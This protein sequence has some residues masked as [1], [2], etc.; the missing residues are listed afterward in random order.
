MF[1]LVQFLVPICVAVVL[2]V[3]IVFIVFRSVM[4]SDNKRAEVLI[5]ALRSN[6]SIDADRL[7][8]ALQKPRKTPAQQLISRLTAGCM[9]SLFGVTFSLAAIF[10]DFADVLLILG[11]VCFAVGI[12][13]LVAYFVSKKMIESAGE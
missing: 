10:T 9:F 6:N 3:M 1:I 8:E 7:A 5:E 13:Y 11:G 12:S 2:P 4:N